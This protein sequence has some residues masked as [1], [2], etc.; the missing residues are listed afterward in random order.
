MITPS[1]VNFLYTFHSIVYIA[2]VAMQAEQ[3]VENVSYV[4]SST[5]P[6]TNPIEWNVYKGEGVILTR[7]G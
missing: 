3:P 5:K 7:G 2:P 1:L 6:T 4:S